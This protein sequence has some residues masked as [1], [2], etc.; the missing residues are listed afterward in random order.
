MWPIKIPQ[1]SPRKLKHH[2]GSELGGLE[3]EFGPLPVGKLG[4]GGMRNLILPNFKKKYPNLSSY[5]KVMTVL[6]KHIRVTVLGTQN[7]IL[8]QNRAR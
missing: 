2:P 7:M 3:V 6:L 4:F 1:F 5:T 8:N